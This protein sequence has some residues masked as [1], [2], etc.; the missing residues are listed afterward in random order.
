MDN[1]GFSDE[2]QRAFLFVRKYDSTK[3]EET[4]INDKQLI[5]MR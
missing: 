4:T 5:E 1:G 3:R 2:E